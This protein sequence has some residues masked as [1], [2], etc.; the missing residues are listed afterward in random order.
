[1]SETIEISTQICRIC[2]GDDQELAQD[3]SFCIDLIR[4]VAQIEV[5]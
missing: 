5:S 4:N 2:L 1:M 3:V